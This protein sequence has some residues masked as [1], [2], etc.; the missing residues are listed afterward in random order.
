MAGWIAGSETDRGHSNHVHRVDYKPISDRT[1]VP[2]SSWCSH[3]GHGRG[4]RP[5][6]RGSATATWEGTKARQTTW[7]SGSESGPRWWRSC[8]YWCSFRWP[9]GG[10]IIVRR[11]TTREWSTGVI[12]G[13]YAS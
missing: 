10:T 5:Q 13:D 12:P 1:P 8:W 2:G 3:F 6:G 9:W 4:L 11:R 7:L